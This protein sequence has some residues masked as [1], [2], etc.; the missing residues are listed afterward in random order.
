MQVNYRFRLAPQAFEPVVLP[1]SWPEDMDDHGAEIQEDPT[2]G[3]IALLMEQASALFLQLLFQGVGDSLNLALIASATN[4][5]V[6][7][8]TAQALKVEQDDI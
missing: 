6:V 3:G 4:D 5:K 2:A 1:L 7:G 8:D